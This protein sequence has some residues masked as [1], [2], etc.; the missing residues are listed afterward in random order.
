MVNK[1]AATVLVVQSLSGGIFS[2]SQSS[3]CCINAVALQFASLHSE[4]VKCDE[5]ESPTSNSSSLALYKQYIHGANNFAGGL[6]KPSRWEA[7]HLQELKTSPVATEP[8][9]FGITMTWTIENHLKLTCCYLPT[10]TKEQAIYT[11][12]CCWAQRVK[13][14]L[15]SV[16]TSWETGKAGSERRRTAGIIQGNLTGLIWLRE[17]RLTRSESSDLSESSGVRCDGQ[18]ELYIIVTA[19]SSGPW[20]GGLLLGQIL[21]G[22]QWATLSFPLWELITS[23]TGTAGIEQV[24]LFPSE[25]KRTGVR[26]ATGTWSTLFLCVWGN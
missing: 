22:N 2:E 3:Y 12:C 1:P 23:F 9:L 15:S 7:K 8:H 14:Q 19:Q 6:M 26:G 5:Q 13:S 10:E 20:T 11:F 21:Q 25:L 24:I 18:L 4:L 16:K 17:A